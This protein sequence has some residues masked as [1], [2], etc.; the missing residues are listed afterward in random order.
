M[1]RFSAL[2]REYR[3]QLHKAPLIEATLR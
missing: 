1:K 3:V 2:V